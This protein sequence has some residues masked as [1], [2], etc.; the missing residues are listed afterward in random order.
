MNILESRGVI[1]YMVVY[2]EFGR[3]NNVIVLEFNESTFVLLSGSQCSIN[4]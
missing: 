4:C 2:I 3:S 1:F